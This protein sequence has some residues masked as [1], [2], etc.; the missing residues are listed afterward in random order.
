MLHAMSPSPLLAAVVLLSVASI[1]IPGAQVAGPRIWATHDGTKVLRDDRAHPDRERNAIWDGSAIHLVAARNETVAFQVIV[2]GGAGIEALT[3]TLPSLATAGGDRIGGAAIAVHSQHYL[4]VSRR[5]RATWVFRD[6]AAPTTPLGWTP[7][8]LVP[9]TARAGRGGMPLAV[10]AGHNQGLWIEIHTPMEAAPGTY[11]GEVVVTADDVRQSIPVRLDLLAVTIPDAPTLPAIV[12]Y[13]RSQTDL[14]HGRN[15]DA[16]YHAFAHRHRVEFTH[17]YDDETAIAARGRFDGSAFS[18][19][20]G[21]EG[22]GAGDGNRVLPR[23]FY[24]PGTLFDSPDTA[25]ATLERWNTTLQALSPALTFVYLPDE[26]TPPQYPRVLA[27]GTRVREAARAVG[28]P[29]KTFLTHGYAPELAD[30]VDIWAAVPAHYDAARAREERK[31]GKQMWFYNGGRPHMG[32]IIVDAP[33]T[34]PRV[35]GW[36]AF[37]HDVDGYFYWHA[38][39]W[40][41]NSQKKIGDRNQD[42]WQEPITFDNR[43]ESKQDIGFINGDGVLVFPGEDVLHPAQDRGHRGPIGTI[44]FANLR[45]GLQDHA[46]LT[47]ARE[48]GLHRDVERAL[49]AVVPRVLSDAGRTV[50]FSEDGNLWERTRRDLLQAIAVS[51]G[52]DARPAPRAAGAR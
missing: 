38:N 39:H 30:A 45:R 14:Y 21:Y 52:G 50:G 7:V 33:A 24:S 49:D 32:A 1:A 18:E 47:M 17:A 3:A 16:A 36:A 5:S 6:A 41:H 43:T 23:T 51:G 28:S 19:A 46:L 40:R 2:E 12:Y 9:S 4:D 35:V 8:A 29:V 34:D 20:A 48:R 13:E 42:V 10:A 37:R 26:P 44:Q 15:M 22:P 31:A 11:T 27:V 25:R